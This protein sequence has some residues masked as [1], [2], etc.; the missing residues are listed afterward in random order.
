MLV[1]TPLVEAEQNGSIR[2]QD[3]TKV[4]MV[5][6]RLGLA[7][8][9]LVPFEAARNVTYADDRPCAFHQIPPSPCPL[10]AAQ[11]RD[12]DVV[13][14]NQA[15]CNPVSLVRGGRTIASPSTSSSNCR[16][17]SGISR[18]RQCRAARSARSPLTSITPGA[19]G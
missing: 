16:R 1:R 4:V 12:G 6:R 13:W 18:S 7:E 9:R 17:R 5:R 8:E 10:A 19:A 14:L 3:L 15:N 2:I 11:H